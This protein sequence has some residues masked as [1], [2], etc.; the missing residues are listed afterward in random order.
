MNTSE[1]DIAFAFPSDPVYSNPYL[2]HLQGADVGSESGQTLFAG[3]S[4]PDEQR[5]TAGRL[6]DTVN[7]E[8]V[9]DRILE[10]HEVHRRV[11]LVVS[12]QR[13]DQDLVQV[14]EARDRHVLGLADTL[15]EVAV[16]QRGLRAEQ[17]VFVQILHDEK[18]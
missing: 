13:L 5:V 4:D 10:Q 15:R 3:P 1:I 18:T 17:V 9:T 16:Q 2:E 6:E 7:A 12:V 11:D 8:D 14:R